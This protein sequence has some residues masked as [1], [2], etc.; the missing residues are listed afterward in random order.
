MQS[1]KDSV[2][3]IFSILQVTN[4]RGTDQRLK[5]FSILQVTNSRG[6]DQQNGDTN[7]VSI[8]KAAEETLEAKEKRKPS[9]ELSGKLAAE[10]NRV[11]DSNI[12]PPRSHKHTRAQINLARKCDFCPFMSDILRVSASQWAVKCL[13][14]LSLWERKEGLRYPYRPPTCRKQHA[15]LQYRPYLMD[16]GSTNGTFM[17]D[18]QIAPQRYYELFEKDTIKFANSREYVLLH[19]N[20]TG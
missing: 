11:K 20:S 16:L 14:L 15:V 1:K 18:N 2:L 3:Q 7:S 6:T 12:P 4:S 10:T 17:N 13:M 19:E 8:M 5:F 9:F